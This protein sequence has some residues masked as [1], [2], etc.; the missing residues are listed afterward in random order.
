[1]T[2]ASTLQCAY[3]GRQFQGSTPSKG[4]SSFVTSLT[5]SMDAFRLLVDLHFS[6]MRRQSAIAPYC[7]LALPDSCT[8]QPRSVSSFL[9]FS[10]LFRLSVDHLATLPTK[11]S[12]STSTCVLSHLHS[13]FYSCHSYHMLSLLPPSQLP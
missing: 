7:L 9:F 5:V 2:M 6:H 4:L 13:F 3:D 10:S 8:S 11:S 1:M 12:I